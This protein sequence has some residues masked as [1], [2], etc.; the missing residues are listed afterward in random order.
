MI[1]KIIIIILLVCIINIYI[2]YSKVI[3][4]IDLINY[5]QQT[6]L[7]LISIFNITDKMA[8]AIVNSSLQTSINPYLIATIASTES[9]FIAT[10]ISPVGY[11]GVMQTPTA[12]MRYVDV[13]FLHGARIL[14]DKL[15]Y[16]KGDLRLALTLYKGGNNKVAKQQADYVLKLYKTVL[17]KADKIKL[18]KT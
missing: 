10:A 2:E 12:T 5:K 18:E 9:D 8:D 4:P 17:E 15:L 14:Q 13:D 1:R 7:K 3:I 16:T 6:I 11:K